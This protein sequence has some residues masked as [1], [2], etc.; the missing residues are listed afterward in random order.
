MKELVFSND[1]RKYG[2]KPLALQSKEDREQSLQDLSPTKRSTELH[3]LKRNGSDLVSGNIIEVLQAAVEKQEEVIMKAFREKAQG[4]PAKPDCLSEF[5]HLKLA[6]KEFPQMDV[7]GEPS[8][9]MLMELQQLEHHTKIVFDK[10]TLMFQQ[11]A[12]KTAPS[13]DK[14]QKITDLSIEFFRYP[15]PKHITPGGVEAF[16]VGA[17][18]KIA[19]P[20]FTAFKLWRYEFPFAMAFSKATALKAASMNRTLANGTVFLRTPYASMQQPFAD[21]S[22]TKTS[23]V[24]ALYK[25]G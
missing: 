6:A 19:Y 4:C 16:L 23:L 11:L 2:K 3:I 13:H 12:S 5:D 7:D 21:C 14:E 25:R 1:R 20:G 9:A 10:Y 17:A 15:P 22:V 8:N 18:F 24:E